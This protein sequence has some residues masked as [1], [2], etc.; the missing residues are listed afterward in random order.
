MDEDQKDFIKN[1][2]WTLTLGAAFQ[3]ANVY[4]KSASEEQKSKFKIELEQFIEAS[5]LPYY[6][7]NTEIPDDEHL[8]RINHISDFTSRYSRILQNGKLNFGVSQKLLN[9]L[10]KYLWCLFDYPIPPHFPLDRRI[11]EYLRILADERNI[12][13]MPI[14]NWTQI[15]DEKIYLSIIDYIRTYFLKDETLAE[16]ELIHFKRRRNKYDKRILN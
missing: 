16:F 10:L 15:T 5:I 11:Q 1:E 4:L 7:I 13:R 6:Q 12:S 2:I 9:L 3:R 8:K 14:T